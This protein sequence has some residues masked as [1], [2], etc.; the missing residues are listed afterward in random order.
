MEERANRSIKCSVEQCE[1]HCN[2]N[3][4]CTLSSV[5]IGTHESH[6]TVW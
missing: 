5:N 4:F 1:H 3:N 2:D 6:P